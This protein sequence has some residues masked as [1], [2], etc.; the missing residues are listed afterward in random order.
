MLS[1]KVEEN[2]GCQPQ[3][4]HLFWWVSAQATQPGVVGMS[5]DSVVLRIR[6]GVR[7]GPQG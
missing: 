4:R 6:N 7:A 2:P 3:P 1:Y 5:P